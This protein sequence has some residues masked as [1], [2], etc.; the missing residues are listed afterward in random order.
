[1]TVEE[2]TPRSDLVLCL[3]RISSIATYGDWFIY[4]SAEDFFVNNLIKI[5]KISPDAN[6]IDNF[7]IQGGKNHPAYHPLRVWTVSFFSLIM[8]SL[9]RRFLMEKKRSFGGRKERY[10]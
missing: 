1:M 2:I 9:D 7:G 6:L 10:R 3:G 8:R 4:I 5:N